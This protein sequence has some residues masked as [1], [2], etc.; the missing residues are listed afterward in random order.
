MSSAQ[1]AR[2]HKISYSAEAIDALLTDLF[3]ESHR[4]APE[5][6]VL[7]LDATDI[8]LYG[9]QPESCAKIFTR[10]LTR[11]NQTLRTRHSN[12]NEGGASTVSLKNAWRTQSA[13]YGEK[14]G[15]KPCPVTKTGHLS[16]FSAACEVVP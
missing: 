10:A 2:Y 5:E 7:D 1:S 9:H 15:L 4:T 6:V 12:G 14:C 3:I 16:S 8:P 11:G 13:S